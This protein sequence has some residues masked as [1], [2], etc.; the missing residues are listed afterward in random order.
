MSLIVDDLSLLRSRSDTVARF[1]SPSHG[2]PL[3]P[4]TELH[5]PHPPC[6]KMIMTPRRCTA[7]PKIVRAAVR[8][9]ARNG[10][11]RRQVMGGIILIRGRY[12]PCGL[13]APRLLLKCWP[14]H[15]WPWPLSSFLRP[16]GGGRGGQPVLRPLPIHR[17]TQTE[18]TRTDIRAPSGTEPATP[19][20][21]RTKTVRAS[22]SAATTTNAT[23]VTTYLL[24]NDNI[25]LNELCGTRPL[26]SFPAF[27]ATR[28]FRTAFTRALDSLLTK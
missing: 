25:Q 16:L 3:S 20:F 11:H 23:T 24:F 18:Q 9:I 7:G 8:K 22:D 14:C 6:I 5:P 10:K 12:Y 4:T 21:E 15:G 2:G 19:A 1:H 27:Y 17:A 26:D 13:P 28:R